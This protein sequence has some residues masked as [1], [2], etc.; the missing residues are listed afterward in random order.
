MQG[1]E[2]G[3]CRFKDE[4]L[5]TESYREPETRQWPPH[6]KHHW[7]RL[8]DTDGEN[9]L[10]IVVVTHRHHLHHR[11]DLFS[12]YCDSGS[13]LSDLCVVVHLVFQRTR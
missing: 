10:E 4:E 6:T 5:Y 9:Q 13:A 3:L 8:G 1:L 11:I 2:I 12:T 7:K